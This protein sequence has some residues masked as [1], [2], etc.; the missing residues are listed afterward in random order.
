[1]RWGIR[2]GLVLCF[3]ACCGCGKK[4][5]NELIADVKG[6]QPRDRLAAVRLLAQRK[7]DAAEVVPVLIEALKD[8]AEDV[9]LSAAIGLGSFGDQAKDA[10]PAL[11]AAKR[12]PD[13]KV[14]E[15]AATALSRIDLANFPVPTKPRGK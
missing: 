14:R 8:K 13:A 10:I 1:M 4:S 2:I 11:Q 9:R 3:L 5:T 6:T 15:A 7:G 12:D